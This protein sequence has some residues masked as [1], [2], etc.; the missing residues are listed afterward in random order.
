MEKFR[1]A[2][3]GGKATAGKKR[4]ACDVQARAGKGMAEF[5]I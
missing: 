3:D 4:G 2:G 1:D 5:M